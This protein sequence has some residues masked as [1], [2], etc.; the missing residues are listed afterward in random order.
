M[1]K[2]FSKQAPP[3]FSACY[4]LLLDIH[5][6]VERLPRSIR[7][8]VGEE[9]SKTGVHLVARITSALSG[10]PDPQVLRDASW[11]LDELRVLVRLTKDMRGMSLGQYEKF[12]LQTDE[13]GRQ[14]GAWLRKKRERA[15]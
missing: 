8:S 7:Y 3:I 6:V 1:A 12:S 2:D 11:R 15:V 14:L 4:A 10:N 13:V 5:K 9:L